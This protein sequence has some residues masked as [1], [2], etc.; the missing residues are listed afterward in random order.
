[1]AK[2]SNESTYHVV[3]ISSLLSR[4]WCSKLKLGLCYSMIALSCA[5]RNGTGESKLV[6]KVNGPND[7]ARRLADISAC[8]EN[9]PKLTTKFWKN[10]II[11]GTKFIDISDLTSNDR[12]SNYLIK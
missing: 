1:M 11:K 7:E 10:H 8:E 9:V 5:I 6:L 2:P 4:D 12:K 3:P